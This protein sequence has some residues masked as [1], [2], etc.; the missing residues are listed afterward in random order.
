VALT[1]CFGSCTKRQNLLVWRVAHDTFG[2]QSGA[3]DKNQS[4]HAL[5][6]SLRILAYMRLGG[7]TVS[8]NSFL[9]SLLNSKPLNTTNR[10]PKPL[11][12]GP[13]DQHRR[14]GGI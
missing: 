8:C 10:N 7:V 4:Q 12:A 3:A 6:I 2:V 14:E 13:V 11:R 9:R 5:Q 1:L